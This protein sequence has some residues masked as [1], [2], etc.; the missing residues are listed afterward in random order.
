MGGRLNTSLRIE[1]EPVDEA[2]LP[3]MGYISIRGDYFSA[4]R[5]PLVAGRVYDASD[6]PGTAQTVI[7]NATAAR[8]FFPK[9]DAVGRRIRIGPDPNGE[10][11]TVIGVVGDIRDEGLD[12]ATKPTLFANDRQAPMRSLAIVVRT[13]G[14]A[15]SAAAVLRGAVKA[16]DATLAVR[17]MKPLTEVI[18]STLAP[19]RFVLGL[20]SCFAVIAL[21]L[22]AIGI[23]GVL[24]YMVTSRLREFGVRLA[25]GATARSV[26]LLVVGQ[27]LGWSLVGLALGVAGAA[28]GGRLLAGSL[29]RVSPVDATTYLSIVVGLLII[30]AIA[31]IVPAARATRVDPLTSMRAE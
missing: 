19:R 28:A 15:R 20:A 14:D 31:C 30:V 5:I 3:D 21:L 22:A 2:H 16:E 13:T 25:L 10:W 11:M 27:G 24:A 29:Y 9:G 7:I 6:A 17:D 4:L 8:Q 26:L 18:G 12:V 23:Y 1:G